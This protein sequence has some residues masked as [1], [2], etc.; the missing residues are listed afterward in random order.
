FLH[1]KLY[2][3]IMSCPIIGPIRYFIV[4]R[5]GRNLLSSSIW[6]R[7]GPVS[8]TLPKGSYDAPRNEA[9]GLRDRGHDPP[10]EPPR[11]VERQGHRSQRL[12]AAAD[13]EQDPE[14]AVARGADGIAPVHQGWLLA[15]EA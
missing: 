11:S 15:L 2:Q 9:G 1:H 7:K 3:S 10:G 5:P 13:G 4:D 12:P 14:A 8:R 6:N